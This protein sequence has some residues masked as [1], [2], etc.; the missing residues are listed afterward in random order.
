MKKR[1]FGMG[2]WN[3]FGGKVEAGETIEE[4]AMREML[5][6]AS[7]S[8][9]QVQEIGRLDFTFEGQDEVLDVR[10]FEAKKWTGEPQESEEM[11]PQWF[12]IDEIP[13]KKMWPADE[14][15]YPLMLAGKK[16]TGH[17]HLKGHTIIL[18]HELCEVSDFS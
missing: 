14:I 15:W 6:E 10:V 11:K 2:W 4:A 18:S 8:V 3:G 12:P 13:F 9:S 1:G 17:F 16:C 7:I 5:E